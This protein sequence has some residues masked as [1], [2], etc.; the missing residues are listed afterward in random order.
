LVVGCWLLV[1]GYWLL[2]IGYWLLVIGYWL[3]VIGY[4]LLVIVNHILLV[5]ARFFYLIGCLYLVYFG[6]SN[7]INFFGVRSLVERSKTH[8]N[9]NPC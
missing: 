8:H 4:W 3:L 2:V 6:R 5:R 1:V 7:N 9:L